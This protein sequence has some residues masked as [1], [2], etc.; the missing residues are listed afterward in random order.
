MIIFLQIYFE[1]R[2]NCLLLRVVSSNSYKCSCSDITFGDLRDLDYHILMS[3]SG[4]CQLATCRNVRNT[5][6]VRRIWFLNFFYF[7]FSRY[8]ARQPVEM[9]HRHGR[10]CMSNHMWWDEFEFFRY[11]LNLTDGWNVVRSRHVESVHVGEC[12]RTKATE[13]AVRMLRVRN[14]FRE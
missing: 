5:Q 7:K 9:N 13:E 14:R 4:S 12:H 8:L 2:L 3:G 10:V 1:T 11:F 6:K